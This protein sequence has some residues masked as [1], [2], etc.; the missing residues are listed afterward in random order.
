MSIPAQKLS[1]GAAVDFQVDPNIPQS[2]QQS[3]AQINDATKAQVNLINATRG[4]RR[5]RR[6]SY[7]GGV[8][9]VMSTYLPPNEIKRCEAL[10]QHADM[11]SG[12]DKQH[13]SAQ[14]IYQKGEWNMESAY[15]NPVE[16]WHDY[17]FNG[18]FI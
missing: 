14:R 13:D 10:A 3:V 5:R 8:G 2:S 17:R 4:G 9:G 16:Q 6:R 18:R 12:N 1:L 7:K 11:H 15:L